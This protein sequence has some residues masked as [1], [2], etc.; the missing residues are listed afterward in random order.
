MKIVYVL[1]LSLIL[2]FFRLVEAKI[3]K[4]K[5]ENVT[6]ISMILSSLLVSFIFVQV[7]IR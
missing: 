5:F 3:R 4:Q 2:I 1:G 7:I 6:V